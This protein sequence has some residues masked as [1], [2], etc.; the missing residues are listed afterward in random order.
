MRALKVFLLVAPAVALLPACS[1]LFDGSRFSSGTPSDGGPAIDGGTT[2]CAMSSDCG[3]GARCVD[4]V[5]TPCDTDG[6]GFVAGDAACPPMGRMIDCDDGDPTRHPGAIPICGNGIDE[7]CGAM[8]PFFPADEIG[9]YAIQSVPVT[10]GRIPGRVR[11]FAQGP[12]DALV[13]FQLDDSRGTPVWGPV[14]LAAE[15]ESVANPQSIDVLHASLPIGEIQYDAQRDPAGTVRFT[16]LIAEDGAVPLKI[17][18][19]S[20]DFL[21]SGMH[22]DAGP[23]SFTIDL[24]MYPTFDVVGAPAL[25]YARGGAAGVGWFMGVPVRVTRVGVPMQTIWTFGV[26]STHFDRTGGSYEP[27]D[28]A[29][30]DGSHAL[31]PGE[32]N[33]Q[34]GWNGSLDST[35]ALDETASIS[36]GFPLT[37]RPGIVSLRAPTAA[38]R[39]TSVVLPRDLGFVVLTSDCTAGAPSSSCTFNP[40][41]GNSYDV[42]FGGSDPRLT[43]IP[44]GPTSLGMLFV[45]NVGGDDE[46]RFAFVET[47]PP[48]ADTMPFPLPSPG[49]GPI[50]DTDIDAT[51]RPGAAAGSV[52]VVLAY[53]YL[54]HISGFPATVSV[55][56]ARVC[57]GFGG[58]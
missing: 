4:L 15:P 53:A 21:P 51:I 19:F 32:F 2:G 52:Q 18:T 46:L 20:T 29:V 38:F 35:D 9:F 41:L 7:T 36:A 39:R 11:V 14:P 45:S 54:R 17:H 16:A 43:S 27:M 50:I 55:G 58:F 31:F 37:G 49:N 25:V 34:I 6:D 30:S 26:D 5:C 47:E 40:A 42:A 44:V 3:T 28:W 57:Q 8:I 1:L 24:A 23:S 48:S 22:E 13:F 10:P 12:D 33:T 56:G